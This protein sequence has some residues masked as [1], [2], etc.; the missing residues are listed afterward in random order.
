[1]VLPPVMNSLII[2]AYGAP[3]HDDEQRKKKE[4]KKRKEKTEEENEIE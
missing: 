4:K 2:P 3:S 1:M